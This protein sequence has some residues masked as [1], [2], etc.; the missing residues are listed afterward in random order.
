MQT[1]SIKHTQYNIWYHLVWCPKYRKPVL[2]GAVEVE[3][4]K[5][6]AEICINEEWEIGSVEVMPDHIHLLVSTP[7]NIAPAEV[8]T[9]IK[10]IT[11]VSL[12]Y[13]FPELKK[14]AFWGSGLWSKG[15]Y[16]GTEGTVTEDAVTRYIAEQKSE[17]ETSSKVST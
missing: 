1:N 12:F 14:R 10:S 15:Y 6:I 17:S 7:P 3:T 2:V 9:R 16:V 5:L 4:K 11:A 8:V 13:R